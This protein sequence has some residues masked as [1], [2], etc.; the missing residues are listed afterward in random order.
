MRVIRQVKAREKVKR[1]KIQRVRVI[2][3]GQ[4]HSSGSKSEGQ[5]VKKYLGSNDTLGTMIIKYSSKEEMLEFTDNMERD[6]RVI[7]K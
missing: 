2:R 3:Q 1:S 5:K 4:G 7:F 6:I